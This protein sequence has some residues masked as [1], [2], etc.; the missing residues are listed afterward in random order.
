[1]YIYIYIDREEKE[2]LMVHKES[3]IATDNELEQTPQTIMHDR[4][5][6]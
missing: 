1:M 6:K 2:T 5:I 4:P 3:M